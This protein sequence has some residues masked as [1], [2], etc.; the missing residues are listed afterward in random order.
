MQNSPKS[1]VTPTI[2]RPLVGV[3]VSSL[4]FS[5]PPFSGLPDGSFQTR[6][7]HLIQRVYEELMS[8]LRSEDLAEVSKSSCGWEIT[9]L[10]EKHVQRSWVPQSV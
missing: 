10:A 6:N 7:T 4:P 8:K 9:F 5:S 3:L 1:W 2:P